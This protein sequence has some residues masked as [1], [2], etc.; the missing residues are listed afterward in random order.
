MMD[1]S[2]PKGTFGYVT[3]V[4]HSIRGTREIRKFK[5]AKSSTERLA[6]Q[7]KSVCSRL[8]LKENAPATGAGRVPSSKTKTKTPIWW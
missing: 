5:L 8:E 7:A 6:N 2:V 4:W 3:G 1:L